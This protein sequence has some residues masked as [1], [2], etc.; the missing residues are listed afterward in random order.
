MDIKE[1]ISSGILEH[2]ILNSVTDQERREVE[3][4]SK[5]YPEISDELHRVSIS[6]ESYLQSTKLEPPKSVHQRLMASI[7][8]QTEMDSQPAVKEKVSPYLKAPVKF[9][10]KN[11]SATWAIAAS[12]IIALAS[13]ALYIN[14]DTKLKGLQNDL[15]SLQAEKEQTASQTSMLENRLALLS[16][17]QNKW[18]ALSGL[19]EK[20]ADYS[21]MIVWDQTSKEVFIDFIHL[22]PPPSNRQYQLWAL[23][24]GK[25]IDLGVFDL[26]EGAYSAVQK[27]KSIESADAFAITLE[28]KGGSVNPTM[29]E[30]YVMGKI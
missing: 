7:Q 27:M 15:A 22:P 17:G 20:S 4:M 29:E 2:Y 1:Y 30:L 28:Q 25:P 5:I 19:P 14:Q 12:I 9:E 26:S 3:C 18:V 23:K 10:R 6:F 8:N 11:Y 24:D 16:K 21:A 13:V